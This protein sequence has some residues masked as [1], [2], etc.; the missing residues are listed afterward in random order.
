MKKTLFFATLA[1]VL[2]A[3]C[4]NEDFVGD[5]S[6]SSSSNEIGFSTGV[7]NLTRATVSGADAAEKLNNNFVVYGYKY[8]GTEPTSGKEVADATKQQKVFER[9]NVNYVGNG[10]S[11]KTNA[12]GWEYVG[13]P[14]LQGDNQTIKYWDYTASGYVFSAI[15]GVGAVGY[16]IISVD[17]G[18]TVYDKG[19]TVVL[20]HGGSLS[21]LYASARKPLAKT[22]GSDKVYKYP[23]TVD[24]TFY[25]MASKVRFGIY[26][27]VPGYSVK[28]DKFYCKDKDGNF[29]S[30]SNTT[31]NF[32]INGT[33][34]MP[35]KDY[36]TKLTVTYYDKDSGIENRPKVTFETSQIKLANA[37]SKLFG[38]NMAVTTA[39]G[40]TSAQATFDQKDGE[41]TYILPY[42]SLKEKTPAQN[43]LQLYVDFTLTAANG[44]TIKVKQARATVPTQYTQ[45]KESTAYTY[46]FK[47]SDNV[48]G[49][50]GTPKDDNDP[51]QTWGDE[52]HDPEGL[53]TITFDACVVNEDESYAQETVTSVT[54]P[55]ITTY[56][57]GVVAT[58]NEDYTAG[59]I[60]YSAT[61]N[62]TKAYVST[63]NSAVYEVVYDGTATV[64]EALVADYAKCNGV[65]LVPV[66]T[67]AE[68]SVPLADNTKLT[69]SNNQCKS[70]SAAAGKNYVI[71]YTNVATGKKTFKVVRVCGEPASTVTYS[72][73]M[74]SED[75]EITASTKYAEFKLVNTN[76]TYGVASANILGAA[77]FFK[78]FKDGA[79]VTENF[80]IT[81]STTDGNYHIAPTEAYVAAGANGSYTVKYGTAESK[82]FIVNFEYEIVY[83][84]GSTATVVT[85]GSTDY[86]TLKVNGEAYKGAKIA[87]ALYGITVT[88]N[89]DGTY[90]IAADEEA[91]PGAPAGITIAGQNVS[92]TVVSYSFDK[93]SRTITWP[94]GKINTEIDPKFTI[95]LMKDGTNFE[96]VV[97]VTSSNPAVFATQN[98]DTD[99]KLT[100]I[101]KA[102]GN[103]T[104]TY[105]NAEFDYYVYQYE[106]KS[107]VSTI[108]KATGSTTL[109]FWRNGEQLNPATSTVKVKNSSSGDYVTTGFSLTS[110]GQVL[111]FGNVVKAGSYR[112]EYYD[113]ALMTTCLGYE[114]ITVE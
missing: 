8:F 69:F 56:A 34:Y 12:K 111:T 97:E 52:N 6:M 22:A 86:V 63:A 67:K 3:S 15:S 107:S 113:D 45:W 91:T 38:A 88:D 17:D 80:E 39:I 105:E 72:V 70:F 66:A 28:I 77:K 85:N 68:T 18:K 98:T 50:T 61:D 11:T 78:V 20:A 47:I 75:Q 2:L 57:K 23:E 16:K 27:T 35:D 62:S 29:T 60:Y 64:T 10:G 82:K 9:F 112:I 95:Q 102:G 89:G 110:D 79:D 101:P 43:E 58:A 41:Y 103:T 4:T 106:L 71:V 87:N 84:E 42:Q 104:L 49:T 46:L 90:T 48:N 114:D 19:W 94:E 65:I 31:T 108:D 40:E 81:E 1:G 76:T 21:A 7:P 13:Y 93:F 30:S 96:K 24:L 51:T 14:D 25:S 54:T 109:T 100:L 53:Y 37:N 32:G 5:S 55:S 36:Q 99:G 59:T 33:F 92:V 73:A 74:K 26:E 83:N 44:E